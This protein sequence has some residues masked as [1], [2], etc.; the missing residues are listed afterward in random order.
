MHKS[1]F[2]LAAPTATFATIA[3]YPH[4]KFSV[5][6]MTAGLLA[7]AMAI[8]AAVYVRLQARSK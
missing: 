3:A 4:I 7:L 5:V 8:W 6:T 2:C 1:A